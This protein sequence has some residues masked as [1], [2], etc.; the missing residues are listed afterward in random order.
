[1]KKAIVGIS[2]IV[3]AAFVILLSVNAQNGQQDNKKSTTEKTA[4]DCSASKEGG[5][6]C[7][8][9]YGSTAQTGTAEN[10]CK[11]QGCDKTAAR[12]GKCNH[13]GCK[14]AAASG[15]EKKGDTQSPGGSLN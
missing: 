2:A 3:L 5:S 10:K 15:E 9:K 1:M 14:T 8:M 11:D 13:E 4:K 6:C 7:K 12:D